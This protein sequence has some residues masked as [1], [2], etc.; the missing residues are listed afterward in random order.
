M[1]KLEIIVKPGKAETVR[2]AIEAVGYPGVTLSQAEGHGTQKGLAQEKKTG[3]YRLEL[4][5]KV[6]MEVVI[7]DSALEP[8]IE[9][10]IKAARTGQPGDGKIFISDIQEVVRIRTG[11]RG[12]KAV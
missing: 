5:P 9:A 2:Q 8:V 12:D 7:P 6:R 3:V 4:V 10:A 1:K 11:E